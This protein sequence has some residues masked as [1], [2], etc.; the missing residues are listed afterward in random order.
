MITRIVKLAIDPNS[1]NGRE[2]EKIFDT[3]KSKIANQAGCLGVKM[4]RGEQHYFTYSRWESVAHL[5]QYRKSA[6][7]GAVWP[8]TKALF[9]DK[10]EAWTLEELAE[11]TP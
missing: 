3:S 9:Y 1:P 5:N 2:F 6:L 4:L 7:F 11:E 10:P 8:R